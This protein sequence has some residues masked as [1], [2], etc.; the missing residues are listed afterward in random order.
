MIFGKKSKSPIGL[1]ISD[2]SL[3][4]VQLKASRGKIKIQ[5]LGKKNIPKGVIENGV[6]L[7]EGAF[8]EAVNSII[9]KPKFGTISTNEVVACLP[10]TKTF[11]KT[12]E[13]EASPNKISDIVESQIQKS[14][15]FSIEELYYDWQ[16]VKKDRNSSIVLVGAAPKSIVDQYTALLNQANLS[17]R[18]FEIEGVAICRAILPEESP[19]FDRKIAK[20]YIIIDIG[21][22]RASIIIYA[23]NSVVTSVSLPISGEETTEKIS[24]TLEIDREQAE[25]AKIICGLDKTKAQGVICEILSEKI[26]NL[27][28]SLNEALDFFHIHHKDFGEIDEIILCGGGSNIKDLDKRIF[29]IT[30]IKTSRANLFIN[31]D[32][33]QDKIANL[34]QEK[35]YAKEK[36]KTIVSEQTSIYAYATTI[37]LALR[38]IFLKDE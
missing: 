17:I 27:I 9:S 38:N 14:F 18:A 32:D 33:N 12:I 28:N 19:K 31:L 2:L 29:E 8:L 34:L 1:D 13:I 10:E 36:N 11:V 22:K 37:G 35:H 25:K 5:A 23:N 20:N 16:V 21:A 30:N 6:V 24:K 15:P 4:L 26:E 7:N 3:K